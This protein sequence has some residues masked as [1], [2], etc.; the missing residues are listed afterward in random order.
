MLYKDTRISQKSVDKFFTELINCGGDIG[1]ALMSAGITKVEYNQ[2]AM[3]D[4]FFYR[5][6]EIVLKVRRVRVLENYIQQAET[7]DR[8]M[9]KRILDMIDRNAESNKKWTFPELDLEYTTD[10]YK[11]EE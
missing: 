8:F 7:G 11:F 6:Q 3:D 2:L 9:M 4:D 10:E 1:E 5:M